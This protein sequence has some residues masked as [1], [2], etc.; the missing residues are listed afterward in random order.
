MDFE[1]LLADYDGYEKNQQLH[2]GYEHP[3][4]KKTIEGGFIFIA[5]VSSADFLD[6][7][8]S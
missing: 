6:D 7:N 4:P 1:T 8:K 3:S 2:L 5:W